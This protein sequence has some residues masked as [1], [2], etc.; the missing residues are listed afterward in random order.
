[1]TSDCRCLWSECNDAEHS[2]V[3]SG[4]SGPQDPLQ[5]MRSTLHEGRQACSLVIS[6]RADP[7]L[8]RQM[9]ANARSNMPLWLAT[10]AIALLTKRGL[11]LSTSGRV[12]RD[13]LRSMILDR[14]RHCESPFCCSFQWLLGEG[15]QN[16]TAYPAGV[17]LEMLEL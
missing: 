9:A 15:L 1:M 2:S 8:L 10:A 7:D 12:M 17:C 3:E 5:C 14:Y 6:A 13:P 4:P 16:L 11:R